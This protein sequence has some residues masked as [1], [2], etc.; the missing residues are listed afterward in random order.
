MVQTSHME[1]QGGGNVFDYRRKQVCWGLHSTDATHNREKGGREG[2]SEKGGRGRRLGTNW[3]RKQ[4]KQ[5][6]GG[7]VSREEGRRKRI[8]K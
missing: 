4:E 5:I 6:A 3:K 8:Q 1:Q 2:Q 7:E